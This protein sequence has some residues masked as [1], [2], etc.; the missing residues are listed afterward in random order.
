MGV[1]AGGM[2]KVLSSPTSL[3]NPFIHVGRDADLRRRSEGEELLRDCRKLVVLFYA[4]L[5]HLW[6]ENR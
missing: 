3:T 1:R 4:Y 2:Q 6:P 5:S